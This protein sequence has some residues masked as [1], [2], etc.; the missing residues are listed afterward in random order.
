MFT[1]CSKDVSSSFL[2]RNEIYTGRPVSVMTGNATPA[3]KMTGLSPNVNMIL[4]RLA[5]IQLVLE[6]KVKVK[7][8]E[9]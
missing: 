9:I 7:G 5:R 2:K 3:W 1:C 4:P 6:V 8:H